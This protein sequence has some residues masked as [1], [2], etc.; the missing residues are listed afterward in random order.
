MDIMN[1]SL[2]SS[3]PGYNYT[4]KSKDETP[5]EIKTPKELEEE[6]KSDNENTIGVKELS[7]GEKEQVIDLQAR[8]AE[9]K[10][11]EAAH[12]GGGGGAATYTYQQGPD[13]KMY[14][15]G[16]E[17]SISLESGSTPEETIANA[18]Q[19]IAAATAP[20]NPSSQDM[21]VA[22]SAKSMIIKAQQEKAKE[23]IDEAEG[24]EAYKVAS[25]KGADVQS[26]E[27]GMNPLSSLNISA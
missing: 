20:A 21:A 16:G 24:K 9:V 19:V 25:I 5:D 12:Q 1:I 18:Q 3:I 6:E 17:V 11:H 4:L 23:L 26:N 7:E 27:E 13:G 14:A 22:A 10:A 8:D 15:I 2:N